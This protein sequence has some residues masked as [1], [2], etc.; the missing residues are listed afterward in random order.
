MSPE[1]TIHY[2]SGISL[3]KFSL[4]RDRLLWLETKWEATPDLV[5]DL[6]TSLRLTSEEG[7]TVWANDQP[8]VT[9]GDRLTSR[10]DPNTQVPILN[11]VDIPPET[12]PGQYKLSLIVYDSQTLVPAAEIDL[13]QTEFVLAQIEIQ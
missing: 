2:D 11:L 10:W 4:E 6:K 12:P 1:R 13:W 8:L 3:L 9:M 5:A 7:E